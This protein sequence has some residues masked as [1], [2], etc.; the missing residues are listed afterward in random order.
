MLTSVRSGSRTKRRA[1]ARWAVGV[2]GCGNIVQNV[3]LPVLLNLDEVRVAWMTNIDKKK[4]MELSK[5]SGI[6]FY[7]FNE[8]L[9]EFEGAGV[10][11]IP[12]S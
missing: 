12:R 5:V 1:D 6:P 2:I 11:A 4:G 8:E 9:P 3:H 7:D 10:A